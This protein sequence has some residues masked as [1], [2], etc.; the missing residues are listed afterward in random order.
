MGNE[1]T[2]PVTRAR[3]DLP[4][5]GSPARIS[6]YPDPRSEIGSALRWSRAGPHA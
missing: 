3:P 4:R 2:G 5:R 1:M 6:W